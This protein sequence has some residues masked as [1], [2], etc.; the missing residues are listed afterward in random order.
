MA[1]RRRMKPEYVKRIEAYADRC[2]H[3]HP[4]FHTVRCERRKGDH[5][6]HQADEGT[7]EWHDYRRG[8]IFP[9]A[10]EKYFDR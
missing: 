10:E 5:V 7:F 3:R 9:W 8:G 4:L 1:L 2:D 6:Y